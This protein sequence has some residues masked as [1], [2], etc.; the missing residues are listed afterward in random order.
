MYLNSVGMYVY[1]KE[2]LIGGANYRTG[3]GNVCRGSLKQ[4]PPEAVGTFTF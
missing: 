3:G 1:R 4:V 2:L